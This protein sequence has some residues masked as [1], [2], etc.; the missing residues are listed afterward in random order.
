LCY[1]FGKIAVCT[2]DDTFHNRESDLFYG[3]AKNT[4]LY[5]K[6]YN[7]IIYP[8]EEEMPDDARLKLYMI[9]SDCCLASFA[10]T[11]GR[12]ECNAFIRD[13]PPQAWNHNHGFTSLDHFVG[14]MRNP[15]LCLTL[16]R[17]LSFSS[18]QITRFW[19]RHGLLYSVFL[20]FVCMS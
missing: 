19:E 9:G 18:L 20:S 7:P 12:N 6:E 1:F 16:T 4:I 10:N 8:S 13:I 15:I 17:L 14:I 2:E 5:P 11:A 3:C